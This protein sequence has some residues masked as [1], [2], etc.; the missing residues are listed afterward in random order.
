MGFWHLTLVISLKFNR[1]IESVWCCFPVCYVVLIVINRVD[2]A[3]KFSVES[4]QVNWIKFVIHFF[5][6]VIYFI[7]FVFG[8]FFFCFILSF[9]PCLAYANHSA[10]FFVV[11]AVFVVYDCILFFIVLFNCTREHGRK[12]ERNTSDEVIRKQ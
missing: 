7:W 9:F 1:F 8:K 11:V 6:K 3:T 2:W 10:T 12:R 4:F 5:F